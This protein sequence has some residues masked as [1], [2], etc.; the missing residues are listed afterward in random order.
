MLAAFDSRANILDSLDV[1]CYP[2]LFVMRGW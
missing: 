1:G 2:S